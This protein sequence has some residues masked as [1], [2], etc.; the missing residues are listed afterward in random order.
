[1]WRLTVVLVLLMS[2]CQFDAGSASTV[3]DV[4][5]MPLADAAAELQSAGLCV[6]VEQ[7]RGGL[8]QGP[9]VIAQRPP[10]GSPVPEDSLVTVVIGTPADVS[11]EM[12]DIGSGNAALD[13]SVGSGIGGPAERT[14]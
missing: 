14:T 11:A 5:E 6:L 12:V 7:G 10:A 9:D 4:S 2:S 8:L 13:C 1:M 3:P